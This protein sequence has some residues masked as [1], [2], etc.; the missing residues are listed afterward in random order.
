MTL[1]LLLLLPG[2][3]QFADANSRR[4][5]HVLA[6]LLAWPLDVLLAHTTWAL[7]AGWPQ[8]GELTISDT[9]ERLCHPGN[10]NHPDFWLFVEIAKK[11]NRVSPTGRHI[12][13]ITS[14]TH[15]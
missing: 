7:L 1:L 2:A 13:I 6:A 5:H 14:T 4:P 10:T 3:L 11:I 8:P 12:Q 9:L 15:S